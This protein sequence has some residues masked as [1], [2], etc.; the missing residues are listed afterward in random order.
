VS[1]PV[2]AVFGAFFGGKQHPAAMMV[3][4]CA[5]LHGLT[6]QRA[7][8]MR[9]AFGVSEALVKHWQAWWRTLPLSPFWKT[10]RGRL[11]PSFNTRA[12][13]ITLLDSFPGEPQEKLISLL[14]LLLPL[15]SRSAPGSQAF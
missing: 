1:D 7:R 13:P 12:L 10:V 5:L 3:V 6:S 8:G 11:S 2:D 15:S 14:R 9:D 4:C